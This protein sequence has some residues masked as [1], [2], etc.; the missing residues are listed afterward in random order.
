MKMKYFLRGFGAGIVVA[1][2]ILCVYYRQESPEQT[3]IVQQAKELGMVFPE[4]TKAPEPTLEPVLT[5]KPESSTEVP[6]T[7][8]AEQTQG[9]TATPQLT[10]KPE[11]SVTA[12]PVRKPKQTAV[13]ETAKET[14]KPV[15]SAAAD[16][17]NRKKGT[18]F[19]VRDG[20][21]SSSVAREMKAAGIIKSDKALDDY[22]EKNGY[23]SSIREGTYWIPEGASY[24]EIAKI[25]TGKTK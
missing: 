21:L 15:G 19:T 20:L 22:M 25:I 24:E 2:L 6:E 3:N 18:R 5:E 1:A 8:K 4:G 7:E 13:P 12:Q 17:D 23:A 9:S 14:K 11:V 10:G 16:A